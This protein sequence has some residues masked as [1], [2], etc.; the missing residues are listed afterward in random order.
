MHDK[1]IIIGGG[2]AGLVNATLLAR[3]GANVTL[4]EKRA[5]PFH[6]VCGEYISNEVVPFLTKERLFPNH[7]KTSK[8]KQFQFT[9]IRGRSYEMPLDL[10]GFGIS[11]YALDHFLVEKAREAGVDVREREP[12]SSVSFNENEFQVTT[13]SG[14]EFVADF[15]IGAYG[16]NGTLDKKLNRSFIKKRSPFIG[17]KYHI[18]TDFPRDRIALHN[19]ETGYCGI[20]AVEGERYNLC[21]LGSRESLRNHGSIEAMEEALLKK[22]PYLKAILEHSDFL[23][24]KPEVI[25]EFSF[26]PKS[27][28]ED[29][30]LM[31]GDTAGLITPL[32]GNGMAMAIHSAKILSEI[33]TT[34]SGK[35]GINRKAIESEYQTAWADTF[36]HRL[37][38]GR[39]T[40][41]LFGS[42]LT[43]EIAVSLMKTSPW[44]AR[45][46]MR[47]THGETF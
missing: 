3:K 30:M 19:F 24:D 23:F 28:I 27:L 45:K 18:K 31:S 32:C 44:I 20:S 8:I 34:H 42:K 1:I 39:Q 38:V 26:K 33:I 6:K 46:I 37:W 21:Y 15:V 11:R 17:V 4:F 40:Q 12:I 41:R 22:N 9:S 14:S 25:N 29:H 36:R 2:L 16:K 43:S 13:A 35:R 47:G 7:I 10:G 5:Y